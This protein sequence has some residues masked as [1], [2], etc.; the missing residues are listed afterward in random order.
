[1]GF[2]S[3]GSPDDVVV[4]SRGNF[5][6]VDDVF[7]GSPFLCM[8]L[9]STEEETVTASFFCPFVIEQIWQTCLLSHQLQLFVVVISW[10]SRRFEKTVV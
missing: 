9:A 6:P 7:I 8:S 5:P 10:L 1:M 2:F 4:D 3:L